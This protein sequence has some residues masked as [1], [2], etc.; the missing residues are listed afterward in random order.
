M[1]APRAPGSVS[2]SVL[3]GT[4]ACATHAAC[5]LGNLRPASANAVPLIASEVARAAVTMIDLIALPPSG[6]RGRA[7]RARN[8]NVHFAQYVTQLLDTSVGCGVWAS[9]E[10]SGA[11][12]GSA[13]P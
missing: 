5:S 12:A 11:S 6:S 4:Q 3:E 9:A 13:R 8:I 10:R 2:G 7:Q 1:S